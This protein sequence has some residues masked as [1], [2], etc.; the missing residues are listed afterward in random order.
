MR[1]IVTLA[2]ALAIAA[3]PLA[4][5]D[6]QGTAGDPGDWRYVEPHPDTGKKVFGLFDGHATPEQM[7]IEQ[8]QWGS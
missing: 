7:K 8:Q 2:T 6:S 5:A 4:F 1:R 3:A